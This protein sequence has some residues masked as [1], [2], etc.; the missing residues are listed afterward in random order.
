M[1]CYYTMEL[2]VQ[3][4]KAAT[5]GNCDKLFS[6]II[7]SKLLS[8]FVDSEVTNFVQLH[9]TACV[10]CSDTSLIKS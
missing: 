10:L 2:L 1:E 6:V 3:P 4:I 8:T 9:A 7:F 5:L